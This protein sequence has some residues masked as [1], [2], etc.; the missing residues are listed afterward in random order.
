MGK[1]IAIANQKGGVAK[2]TTAVNLGAWLSL[3]GQKVL[4]IDTDPQGNATTGVGV[5]KE[6]VASCIYDVLINKMPVRDVIV[7][8][9][10]ENLA[11]LPATIELAGAEIEL[12]GVAER[13]HVLKKALA[14]IKDDYDFIFI[15]CPPSLG[16]LT[17]NALTAADS[18]LIPIQCEYYALEGLGQLLNTFQRVQQNLNKD[19]VLEGVLLTMFDGRTNLSIQVVDEVKKYFKGKVYRAIVPRNVRLS[20]A[21][22][23]GKPVMVYDR[24]SKGSEVYHELAKEVMGV[25]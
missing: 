24:R 18:L 10:V 20:E 14:E 12:V 6:A 9:A 8:S 5:D 1:T 3:M 23:H 17:I 15:D 16:L 21:P 25:E 22:S 13:E 7:P 2:T 4:L 19:L 11:L